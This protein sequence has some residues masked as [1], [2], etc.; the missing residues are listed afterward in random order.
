M[1]LW[2]ARFRNL[3]R[4]PVCDRA[5]RSK[6]RFQFS[7]TQDSPAATAERLPDD[8]IGIG[9]LDRDAHF[10]RFCDP[11]QS[12]KLFLGQF[13]SFQG[14]RFGPGPGPGRRGFEDICNILI[15]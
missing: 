1:R 6:F 10:E 5:Q 13:D 8:Y 9:W 15:F 14:S 3:R 7:D 4:G 12:G 2:I 11:T